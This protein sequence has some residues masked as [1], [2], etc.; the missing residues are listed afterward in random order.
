MCDVPKHVPRL[1][2]FNDFDLA[3]HLSLMQNMH[4]ESNGR[5]ESFVKHNT[6]WK[7]GIRSLPEM[8]SKSSR[9]KLDETSGPRF[10]PPLS[11]SHWYFFSIR[12]RSTSERWCYPRAMSTSMAAPLTTSKS[13]WTVRL[14]PVTMS[15]SYIMYNI[16]MRD[17]WSETASAAQNHCVLAIN[18]VH[19]NNCNSKTNATRPISIKKWR[20]R[21]QGYQL[22]LCKKEGF[23]PL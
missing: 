17:G 19:I 7:L 10:M 23:V 12:R 18:S 15:L 4:S 6:A 16:G 14:R 9:I 22:F 20:L 11:Y 21:R 5:A 1:V 8:M 2:L 3:E 13:S